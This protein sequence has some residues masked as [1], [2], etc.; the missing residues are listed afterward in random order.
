MKTMK[1]LLTILAVSNFFE[2]LHHQKDLKVRLVK[3]N[4]DF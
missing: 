4:Q 2:D 3:I 1:K